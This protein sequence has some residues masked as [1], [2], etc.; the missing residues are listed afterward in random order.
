MAIPYDREMRE[1][2]KS[3]G[4]KFLVQVS[5]D[6]KYLSDKMAEQFQKTFIGHARFQT[7]GPMSYRQAF[8]LWQWYRKWQKKN[9]E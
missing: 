1:R 9:Q 5:I 8:E 6:G 3:E 2:A 7:T 4:D